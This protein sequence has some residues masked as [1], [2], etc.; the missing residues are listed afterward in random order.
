MKIELAQYAT[1]MAR[2]NQWMNR[3]LYTA[4]ASLNPRQLKSDCGLFFGS[5]QG[6]L[7]HLLVCDRLW[8]SRFQGKPA[9][10]IS[11]SQELFSDFHQL[12]QARKE[13]DREILSWAHTLS[14][15]PPPRRLHY[16]SLEKKTPQSLD[17]FLAVIHFFNHQTHHR[18]QITAELSRLGQ[19]FG[20]TD[21]I[22]MK[23]KMGIQ[24]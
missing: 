24:Q 22:Y 17:F 6:T 1:T 4:I 3:N 12:W 5:I 10:V 21:L 11:L 13:M 2:Y 19:D 8:L 9:P 20:V 16:V 15:S 14:S 23:N 18:G 7:N